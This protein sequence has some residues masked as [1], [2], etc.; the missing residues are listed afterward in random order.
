MKELA[1]AWLN[2]KI[3]TFIFNVNTYGAYQGYITDLH[4]WSYDEQELRDRV[5]CWNGRED[6]FQFEM[7]DY[8]RFN[9]LYLGADIAEDWWILSKEFIKK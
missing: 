6:K 9:A 2:G 4:R 8:N 7:R 1:S 5:C 3:N